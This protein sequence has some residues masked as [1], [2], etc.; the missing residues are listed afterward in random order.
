MQDSAFDVAL[1]SVKIVN[2]RRGKG[3]RAEFVYANMIDANTGDLLTCATLEYIVHR[4]P[5][6]LLKTE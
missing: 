1:R 2:I 6:W 5:T 3:K 4:Y